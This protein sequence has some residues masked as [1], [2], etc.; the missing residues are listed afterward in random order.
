MS[1]I[2]Q[3]P[4]CHT[5]FKVVVDQLKISD[6][7]VRCGSCAAV[8]DA[9][10][11]VQPWTEPAPTAPSRDSAAGEESPPVSSVAEFES[12]AA[13][14]EA[15]PSSGDEMAEAGLG[16]EPPAD[17]PVAEVL[18]PEPVLV[19]AS[20]SEPDVPFVR[21]AKRRAFWQKPWVRLLLGLSALGLGLLLVAQVL[22]DQRHRWVAMYPELTPWAEAI[23]EPLGCRVEPFR[24]IDSVL[25]DSSAL[26][27][28]RDGVYRLE[29]ALK[30]TSSLVLAVPALEFSLTNT[31][32]EVVL[33]RVLV[34]TEWDSPP[35]TLAPHA[36]AALTVRLSLGGARELRM[37]GY[38]ALVFYP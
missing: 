25:I 2:T 16:A 10:L 27:D 15:A 11:S 19:V 29:V 32:D 18:P 21:Q 23:C 13:P 33:R 9:K 26:V 37:S 17:T 24:Q 5:H 20:P 28:E 38:R 12:P 14:A 31:A 4:Q 6:G 8:F 30:N 35:A 7:W 36:T 3:C 22:V 34:P 1:H